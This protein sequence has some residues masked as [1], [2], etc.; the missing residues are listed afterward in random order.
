MSNQEQS[1][2]GEIFLRASPM[3][4]DPKEFSLQHDSCC[5]SEEG[6]PCRMNS[7]EIAG[8]QLE[9][10]Q[11]V[12]K[13]AKRSGI[14]AV[15]LHLLTGCAHE[16]LDSNA[17]WR[18]CIH[19]A[20]RRRD[21]GAACW[22]NQS[23]TRESPCQ[24]PGCWVQNLGLGE[25]SCSRSGRTVLVCLKTKCPWT[26]LQIRIHKQVSWIHG[27]KNNEAAEKVGLGKR[28]LVEIHGMNRT[29]TLKRTPDHGIWLSTRIFSIWVIWLLGH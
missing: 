25:S 24:R 10:D 17:R 19:N 16:R 3:R 27:R 6:N 26:K 1:K 21:V 13:V 28:D 20:K 23:Q 5:L 14:P 8:R 22:R 11:L 15:G 7:W 18:R 29:K 4:W 9:Q 2:E 12:E